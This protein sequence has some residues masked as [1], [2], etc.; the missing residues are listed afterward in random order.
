M[1]N[2]R[3]YIKRFFS[4]CLLFTLFA[5]ILSVEAA[6]Y[7]NTQK[8]QIFF[9][10]DCSHSMTEEQWQEA[11]DIVA[12]IAA[13]LPSNYETAVMAYNE[14]VVICTEFGQLPDEWLDGLREVK[15]KGYTNTGLAVETALGQFS[16]DLSVEKRI[17]VVSDGEIS[18]KGNTETEN[19]VTLYDAAVKNASDKNVKID[20]LLF[21]SQDVE[22]QISYGAQTTGGVIY[23]RKGINTAEELAETY[24]FKQLALNRIMLGVSDAVQN[25]SVVSLQDFFAEYAKIVLTAESSIENIQVSC[26]SEDIQIIQGDKFAVISLRHPMEENVNLQYTLSEQGKLSA[27]LMKEYRLSVEMEAVHEEELS[28][29]IVHVQVK[30]S[31]GRS[32][33]TDKDVCEKIDIYVNEAKCNY[34][35]EQGVAVIGYPIEESQEITVGVDFEG[36][37]SLVFC[38][39]TEGKLWLELPPP[40]PEDQNDMQYFWLCTVVSGVCIIFVLLVFLL[41]RAKKKTKKPGQD[42]QSPST[43]EIL[44]YDF[45]GKIVVYV[46][47]NP[48]W[49]D[50]PPTSINLYKREGRDPFT[51]AW[52]R[53]KCRIDTKLRDADKVVFSGGKNNT[54]CV[55]NNGDVTAFSGKDILLRSKKYT[56]SY[57]EKLLL[58]FNDG[59]VELEIHY[60]N[61]KP[62]ER[63]R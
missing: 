25:T 12:M 3:V 33:L 29:H 62:S 17:V 15:R 16:A 63:E 24:L 9:T 58:I 51:F 2:I 14:D 52:V 26:Q 23:E 54:L 46:L 30:D 27:Y 56:L 40:E 44:K 21:D 7:D 19:A 11:V 18:M 39:E 34:T 43:A 55:R 60:K 4:V 42:T 38:D 32:I 47:K 48:G 20:I 41:S 10:L 1:R 36:L 8:N 49:E 5:N 61:I 35:E 57:D 22:D 28:R 53:D 6:E 59:E 45:S 37:N 13:A 31:Q 50:M